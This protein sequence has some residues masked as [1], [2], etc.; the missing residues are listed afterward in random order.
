MSER[1]RILRQLTESGEIHTYY[2]A[3]IISPNMIKYR[4]IYYDVMT[5]ETLGNPRM[6]AIQ[7]VAERYRTCTKTVYRAIKWM[8]G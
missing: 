6:V 5:L 1:E 8:K 4:D 7:E 2:K 3:G